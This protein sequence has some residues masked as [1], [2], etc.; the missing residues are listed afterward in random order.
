MINKTCIDVSKMG[1]LRREE[2]DGR[3]SPVPAGWL[4]S[5]PKGTLQGKV[6]TRLEMTKAKVQRL[7]REMVRPMWLEAYEGD[8]ARGHE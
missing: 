8:R 2:G 7:L 5:N 1:R 3:P 4:K 6:L